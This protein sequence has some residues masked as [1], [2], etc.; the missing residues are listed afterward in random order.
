MMNIEFGRTEGYQ[1]DYK[2]ANFE[3]AG[4]KAIVTGGAKGI[5]KA[6]VKGYVEQFVDVAIVDI[7]ID[8]SYKTAEEFN[9]MR[10]GKVIVVPCD[11]TKPDQVSTMVETV[12][13]EFGR[14]D[15]CFNNAGIAINEPAESMKYESWLKLM[16][17]N[18]NAVFLV[19]QAVGRVMI[20][21]REGSIINT[22]SMS[23]YVVNFPQPQV[24]YNA[25]KAAVIQLSKS[26][27]VE[28]VR[29]NVRVNSLS[30]GYI[31]TEMTC[32]GK[33]EWR[34]VWETSCPMQRMGYPQELVGA[35]LYL[36]S[37]Y[38]KFMSGQDMLIDG[39]FS[40]V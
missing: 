37:D 29:H 3:L 40:A 20:K 31:Y 18:L 19:A 28:W 26:L 33:E 35:I 24:G 17:I 7:D 36:S 15:A 11:V 10:R 22:A 12:L 4:K 21:Q 23:G 6:A 39:A 25:S 30:P 13:K 38:S 1:G 16:D 2:N 14:I 34:T 5:G 8:E 27:A 9:E 32:K